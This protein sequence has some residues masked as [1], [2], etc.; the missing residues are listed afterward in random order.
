MAGFF[1]KLLVFQ[2]AVAQGLFV[3]A[4]IGVLSSVVAA[5]YYLRVIK[6][7]FFDEALDPFDKQMAFAKRAVIAVSVA[8][9]V[10]FVLSPDTLIDTTRSAAAALFLG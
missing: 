1:G 10:L 8:F 3:L 9:V 6:V 5:Y 4:I 2:A 7:M